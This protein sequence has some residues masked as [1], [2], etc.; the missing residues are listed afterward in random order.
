MIIIVE[1]VDGSTKSTQIQLI[2]NEFERRWK[3]CH[4]LHY[5]NLKFDKNKELIESMSKKL[6]KSMF[7]IMKSHEFSNPFD[8]LILDR[9]HIG[10]VIYSPIYRDY[11]GDYVYEYEDDYVKNYKYAAD[12]TKL[13]LFTDTVKNILERDKARGD[14]LSFS[15]DPK[16]KK[17]ELKSFE[18]AVK[19]SKLIHK[20]V[21]LKNRT[22]EKIFEEDVKPFIFDE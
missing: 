18:A 16:I 3:A 4:I 21:A 2:K 22:A 20:I 14:G 11:S 17:L 19:K 13:L 8:I 15:L 1:G 10:E 9:S 5:A 6:Y 12:N 7:D